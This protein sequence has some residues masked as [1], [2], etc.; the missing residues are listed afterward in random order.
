MLRL[1]GNNAPKRCHGPSSTTV[2]VQVY[3]STMREIEVRII[4]TPGFAASDTDKLKSISELQVE[5]KMI[6]CSI[7]L[8]SYP[9]QRLMK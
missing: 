9:I 8:V 3:T 2:K 4:D 5:E 7:A 6:C 1:K